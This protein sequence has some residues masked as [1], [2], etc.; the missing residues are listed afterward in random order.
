MSNSIKKYPVAYIFKKILK[1]RLTGE[2]T[3]QC[4]EVIKI[5]YFEKGRLEFAK[6]N[7][8]GDWLG[9]VLKEV[10]KISEKESEILNKIKK[11][12]TRKAGQIL[13][14]I[15]NLNKRDIQ[16][17]L[18]Q[19]ISRIASTTF[20]LQEGEWK[21]VVKNPQIPEDQKM[22]L[23]LYQIIILGCFS[24]PDL[25]FYK[26]RFNLLCPVVLSIPAIIDRLLEK[27]DLNFLEELRGY[28]NIQVKKIVTQVNWLPEEQFW[29]K[30]VM[31]YLLNLVDF[32]EFTVEQAVIEDT[33]EVN[34]MYQKVSSKKP[35]VYEILD[36][37]K[38]SSSKDITDS[39]L[40]LKDKF[41]P[42]KMVLAP[43][44]TAR[45]RVSKVLEEIDQAFQRL[46]NEKKNE[47]P[48]VEP[49]KINL[50]EIKNSQEPM[51]LDKPVQE[52]AV[53]T[54]PSKRA[55]QLYLQANSLFRSKK[56]SE[57]LNLMEDAVKLENN[58]PSYLL[59]M[60][61]IQTK[62]PLTHADAERNLL[63]VSEQEPW[64]A[65][66]LFIIGEMYRSQGLIK[67]AEGYFRKALEINM[68]HT[69][70]NISIKQIEKGNEKKIFPSLFRN[71]KK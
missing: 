54:N 37:S 38:N 34:D 21:F 44:S 68:D 32:T 7:F 42:Q 16:L 33:E 40:R 12:S 67:K 18:N 15:T 66:P 8:P 2:L 51:L 9:E 5:L 56:Y 19:Q 46:S 6:S 20:R 47:P 36:V 35:D 13:L 14:E 22:H 39:Y 10:G 25:I 53:D 4:Q 27:S 65:D 49:Q 50:K 23:N 69:L 45:M 30:L 26:T 11:Y 71:K 31:F 55:K 17:G 61:L 64:N 60:G 63:K 28:M 43:E 57:A 58:R 59:L 3:I 24:M 1:N 52:S 41:N 62:I 29:K 48:A 70:A